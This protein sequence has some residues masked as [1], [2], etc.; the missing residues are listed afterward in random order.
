MADLARQ[1][2]DLL[3]MC[4]E[5]DAD[6]VVVDSL[7][8]AALGLNDDE[9]GAGYNRARQRVIESGVQMLELHHNRK[10]AQGNGSG[11]SPWINLSAR[12]RCS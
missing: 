11:K 2:R 1:D 9:V 4:R 7:K 10:A 3:A 12:A 8:D 5:A 6:T